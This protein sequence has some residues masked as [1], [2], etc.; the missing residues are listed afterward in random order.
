MLDEIRREV[1]IDGIE[2]YYPLHS[3]EQVQ[4][5]VEYAEKHDLMVSSG[6][7][8][9]GPEKKPIK[10]RAELSRKLLERL[11]IILQEE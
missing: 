8:S 9:H 10:Y 1:P 6:S 3:R 4:M 5:Y 11:G 2:A 7:D